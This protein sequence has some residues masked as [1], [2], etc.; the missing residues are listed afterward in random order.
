MVICWACFGI[1]HCIILE[2]I[3]SCYK[4]PDSS[5]SWNFTRIKITIH[6][7]SLVIGI[8]EERRE[9]PFAS[10]LIMSN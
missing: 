4:M 6:C 1:M 8:Q 9:M 7:V 2:R 3:G 5:H 10:S